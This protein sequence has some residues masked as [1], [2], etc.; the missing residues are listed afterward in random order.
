M[1]NREKEVKI[2]VE[3]FDS[4]I[5]ALESQGAILEK[6]KYFEDNFLFDFP[7]RSLYEKNQLL[8]I[9]K[10]PDN[11]VLTFKGPLRDADTF[12]KDRKEIETGIEDGDDLIQILNSLGF[13][14]VYRYQKFRILYGYDGIEICLDETPIGRYI[15]IEGDPADIIAMSGALNYR[16]EDFITSSYA[17]LH[18]KEEGT[19]DLMRLPSMVFEEERE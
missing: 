18:A 14:R 7:D 15:E 6:E 17:K 12:L 8:R 13:V 10:I 3:S 1:K 16:Q 2:K 5:D 11:C 9:R 19:D 4:V